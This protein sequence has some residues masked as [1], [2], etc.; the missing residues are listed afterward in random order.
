MPGWAVTTVT[1]SAILGI[2]ARAID[3]VCGVS[4]PRRSADT[5]RGGQQALQSRGEQG[6]HTLTFDDS[7]HWLYIFLPRSNWA[8]VY[9]DSSPAAPATDR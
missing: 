3:I 2:E 5:V 4:L 9:E 7:R 6:A 1:V 8:V